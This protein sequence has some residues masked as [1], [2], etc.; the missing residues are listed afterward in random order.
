MVL[1]RMCDAE[2]K[3]F[4]VFCLILIITINSQISLYHQA[5][6]RDNNLFIQTN[7]ADIIYNFRSLV[8]TPVNKSLCIA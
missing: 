7:A 8:K 4:M 3:S 5:D 2:W 6:W 1:V